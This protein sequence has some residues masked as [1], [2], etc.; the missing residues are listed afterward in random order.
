MSAVELPLV[1]GR[2]VLLEELASGGMA[3]VYIGRLVGPA[4]FSRTVAIKRLHP[5]LSKDPEFVAML[6]DEARLA[7]RIQHPNV[8]AT[9][10]VVAQNGELFVVMEYLHGETLSRLIRAARARGDVIPPDV[11][12]AVLCGVLQGLHAAHEARGERGE[13]LGLVHRDISPQNILVREDGTSVVLDF[14]VAKATGRF[15]ET[16][17]G[18]V[19]GKLP[20]MAPEQ[21]RNSPLSRRTDVYAAGVV[22]WEALVGRRLFRGDNDGEVLERLLFGSIEPP[23]AHAEVGPELDAVVLKA[24]EKQADQRFATAREMALALEGAL[25]PALASQVSAWMSELVGTNLEKRAQRMAELESSEFFHLLTPADGAVEAIRKA[26]KEQSSRNAAQLPEAQQVAAPHPSQPSLP[27]PSVLLDAPASPPV[28]SDF[29]TPAPAI[30]PSTPAPAGPEPA[31]RSEK[32][33]GLLVLAFLGAVLVGGGGVWLGQR[34]SG[35]PGAPGP[36]ASS[37][38]PA[39]SALVPAVPSIPSSAPPV[40]PAPPAS[41]TPV[42]ATP[43]GIPVPA[44]TAS[45]VTAMPRKK[46]GVDC[47][48][49]FTLVNGKKVYKRECL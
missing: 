21:V 9:L 49:P 27:A 3:T 1:I 33:R 4:G 45:T 2:Y 11:A 40:L 18:R 15:H 20:Y 43:S 16:S 22:L 25:R 28:P 36:G 26:A 34:S 31:P 41:S 13:P 7:G 12:V 29:A 6:L 19:K 8:A 30:A 47:S 10:D 24:L 44:P 38:A 17:D 39:A 37:G 35:A 42:A 23:S 32:S 48:I 14:G 46:T 5:H